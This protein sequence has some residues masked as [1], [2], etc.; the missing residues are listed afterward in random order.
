MT[1]TKVGR[2][3][4]I[5]MIE[6][7]L[8][9]PKN[10][11][12][13]LFGPRQTGKSTILKHTFSEETTVY[14]N[15]LQSDEYLRLSANP[16]IFRE[17]IMA[18][19]KNFTHVVVDEIQRIPVLLNEIHIL[20]ESQNPPYFCMSGSS[21]RKLKR[22]H[23]NLLAG[24]A[25]TLYLYPFTHRE[26]SGNFLLDKALCYGTLPPVYLDDS[27]ANAA[28]TLKAYVETY[29][30]EE[31]KSEALVR[32]I[33]GFLRFL[34]LA[35]HE[36]GNIINY[37]NISR[38]TGTY[39]KT[40]KEFFQILDDTLV[41]FFILPYSKSSPRKRLVKHP[42]FYFFDTGVQRAI[43]GKLSVMLEK[44]TS[45]YGKVFEHFIIAEILRLTKYSEKDYTFSFYRTESGAEVDLIIETPDGK[46]YAIEIKAADNPPS[47]SLSGLKSFAE[48]CNNAILCCVSL[49]PRKRMLGKVN[50]LPWQEI[51]E[52]IGV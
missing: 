31:I 7:M 29:L 14:Y 19:D 36:N 40:V 12:F 35:G 27:I 33:G 30:E 5:N 32:N 22:S 48:I 20:M 17:E 2:I 50:I 15:L 1:L 51:F 3:I 4:G 13:F 44:G 28:R 41:G 8:K 25:W 9:P 34:K 37:S 6:R 43:T 46:T 11:S 39:Y 10:K 47:G 42:K 21:A 18:R 52:F 45:E 16:S 26:C 49:A 24:R 23:A 38:E